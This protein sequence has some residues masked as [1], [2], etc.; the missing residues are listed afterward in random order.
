MK[1][2]GIPTLLISFGILIG[3]LQV[4]LS[5][6]RAGTLSLHLTQRILTY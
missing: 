5:R 3:S 1:R 6:Q 4:T 2:L